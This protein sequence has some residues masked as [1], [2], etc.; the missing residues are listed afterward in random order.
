MTSSYL[1]CDM[2]GKFGPPAAFITEHGARVCYQCYYY[3]DNE[4]AKEQQDENRR[5]SPPV[6]RPSE[7]PG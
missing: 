5:E 7:K 3:E 2:C 6:E 4:H 1:V